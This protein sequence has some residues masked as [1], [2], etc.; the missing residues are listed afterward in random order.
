MTMTTMAVTTTLIL[1]ALNY[2]LIGVI[3]RLV[4]SRYK[5]P[6]TQCYEIVGA[7]AKFINLGVRNRR[8][9]IGGGGK[10]GGG[11]GYGRVGNGTV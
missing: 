3:I 10:Y 7:A 8:R 11:D 5:Y 4:E 1:Y 2:S 9:K 6:I